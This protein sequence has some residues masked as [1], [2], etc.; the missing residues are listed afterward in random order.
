MNVR[1]Q[2]DCFGQRRAGVLLHLTSLPDIFRTGL[3]GNDVNRFLDFL[4]DAGFSLWQMLPVQPV[5]KYASPYQSSSLHAGNPD[6]ISRTR[7]YL[8]RV[9]GSDMEHFRKSHAAWLDDYV[10]FSA[11]KE[12][13]GGSPWYAWPDDLKYRDEQALSRFSDQHAVHIDR[14]C[15]E[16]YVFFSQWREL[17]RRARERDILL[18]GDMPLFP[19]DDSADVWAHRRNFKLDD[20]GLPQVVAGVPPDYFSASGQ[21]WGN[22]VYDWEVISADNFRWWIDRLRTQLELFD[23]IRMDH[24]RGLEATWEIPAGSETAEK[25]SWVP[26][27]GRELLEVLYANFKPLPII[28]EDL[29]LIS[30]EVA[31]LRQDYRLPGMVILQF[32]FDS[33][34]DNPYLPHNH[35]PDG[36][37][38]T[39]TH[40]NNTLKGWFDGLDQDQRARICDYLGADDIDMPWP[41]IRLALESVCNMAIVPMQD[42]LGLGAQHRMNVPGTRLCNWKWRLE[43]NPVS[44][45]LAARLKLLNQL[46]RRCGVDYL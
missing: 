19:G 6:F 10:L 35:K 31:R 36:V 28:A 26:V 5:N 14:Y 16:Q 20:T 45:Q 3:L 25:G 7:Q 2:H 42:L 9:D 15:R 4:S 12:V 41:M 11:I 44:K 32:A 17:R 1:Q 33:D 40:D 22:P 23:L 34:A 38:Y 24:F 30:A 13:Y 27:P 46:Y 21:R 37:V 18:V 8:D 43:W 29:G 39:G